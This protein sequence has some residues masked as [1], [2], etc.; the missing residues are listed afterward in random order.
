VRETIT[1]SWLHWI[2]LLPLLGAAV[3]LILGR[4]LPR[5]LSAL[6]GCGTVA[7]SCEIGRAH[8]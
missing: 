7:V 5:W 1:I 8:V 4:R 3:N 2:P 6:V